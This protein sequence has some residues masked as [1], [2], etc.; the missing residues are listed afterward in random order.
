MNAGDVTVHAFQ[1]QWLL[2]EVKVWPAQR[3]PC[4]AAPLH[5]SQ[6]LCPLLLL[7]TASLQSSTLPSLLLLGQTSRAAAGAS[8][9]AAPTAWATVPMGLCG[10]PS[11]T[12]PKCKCYSL[13]KPS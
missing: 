3:P 11:I 2:L 7:F 4:V 5:T 13:E 6:P 10:P 1:W 9:F 12:F 8:A